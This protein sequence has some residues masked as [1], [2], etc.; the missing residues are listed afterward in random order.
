VEWSPSLEAH[1]SSNRQGIIL[2]L[3]TQ[4]LITLLTTAYQLIT[5]LDQSSLF[6]RSI[7]FLENQ[8]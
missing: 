4:L 3:Q 8:F 2:I 5:Q 6:P 7:L 1:V